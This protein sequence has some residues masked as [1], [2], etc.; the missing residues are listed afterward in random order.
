MKFT[1]KLVSGVKQHE[2][3]DRGVN[4]TEPAGAMKQHASEDDLKRKTV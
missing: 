2:Y 4:I 3:G 1:A